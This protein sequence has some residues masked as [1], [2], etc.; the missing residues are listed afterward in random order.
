[1]TH[2]YFSIRA[3]GRI[4]YGHLGR[5]NSC[6]N[7]Y[8][9]H[10]NKQ[11]VGGRSPRYAPPL[12][13]SVGAEARALRRRADGNVAAVSHGQHCSRLRPDTRQTDVRLKH[14]FINGPAYYGRGIINKTVNYHKQHSYRSNC[15]STGVTKLPSPDALPMDR[16]GRHGQA[17]EKFV[18]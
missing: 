5:T 7:K 8:T 12:S 4:S 16:I 6:L 1:M 9:V 15:I 14:R 2:M 11:A 13:S 17:C 10:L 18:T 3:E